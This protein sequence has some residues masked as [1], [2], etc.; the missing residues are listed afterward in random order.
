MLPNQNT[1]SIG[2]EYFCQEGDGLWASSDEDLRKL[3]AEEI[4][5][6]AWRAGPT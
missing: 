3:A 5:V 6:L 4:E 1:A 2:M